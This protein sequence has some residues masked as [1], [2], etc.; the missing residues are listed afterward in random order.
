M[1]PKS[2]RFLNASNK[3]ATYVLDQTHDDVDTLYL[4]D[5]RDEG[6]ASRTIRFSSVVK[7]GEKYLL[8]RS[9]S[10]AK[11]LPK[12]TG[13]DRNYLLLLSGTYI[14]DSQEFV[15][16]QLPSWAISITR[17][18]D[19]ARDAIDA[20]NISEVKPSSEEIPESSA[21]ARCKL[22]RGSGDGK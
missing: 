14:S 6:A 7:A 17:M 9:R 3:N 19:R 18:K 21:G 11:I 2:E 10:G 20:A 12:T 22:K 13:H 5:S 1:L 8:P 16:V 15:P 4:L